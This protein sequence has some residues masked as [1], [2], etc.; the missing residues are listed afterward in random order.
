MQRHR[1][2]Q[3]GQIQCNPADLR[4]SAAAPQCRRAPPRGCT[5]LGAQVGQALLLSLLLRVQGL[6]VRLLLGLAVC[7]P[8]HAESYAALPVRRLRTRLQTPPPGFLEG[9]ISV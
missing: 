2:P 8:R 3:L 1:C 7:Q 6:Q 5:R 9:A 4:V